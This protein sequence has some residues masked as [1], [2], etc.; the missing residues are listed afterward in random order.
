MQP[1]AII[2]DLD[3]TLLW[4]KK[5][6]ATAFQVVCETAAAETGVDPDAL[7][8]RVREAARNLYQ[9]YD[10]YPFTQRIGINPFEALWGVFDDAGEAFEKLHALAPGY[11]YAAWMKGLQACGIEDPVLAARLANFFPKARKQHPY[12]FEETLS[13]LNIL[14]GNY[15]LLLLTNGAPSLQRNKLALTPELNSYFDHIVISG[16]VG[17]G[18][19]EREIFEAALDLLQVDAK[20]A[21]MVGDNLHTDIKGAVAAGIPAVWINHHGVKTEQV[22]PDY[23]I[24]RLQAL[25]P[26]LQTV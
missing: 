2:F 14:Q 11:Q 18:K 6:V 22:K 17:F 9:A 15:P 8:A 4:D 13:V 24:D 26:L 1:K 7:E 20:D 12:L 16:D 3:D 10:V 23:E 19:P 25:L 5:S 21:L